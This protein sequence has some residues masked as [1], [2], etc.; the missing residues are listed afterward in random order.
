MTICHTKF[1]QATQFQFLSGYS[2]NTPHVLLQM[3]V[4]HSKEA[5]N[6]NRHDI[7]VII[8]I[9]YQRDENKELIKDEDDVATN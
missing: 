5:F 6:K 9:N 3:K 1:C 7:R 4:S 8:L 2:V